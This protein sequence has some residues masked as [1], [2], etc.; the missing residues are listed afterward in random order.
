M[1]YWPWLPRTGALWLVWI[2]WISCA[3]ERLWNSSGN[4]KPLGSTPTTVLGWPSSSMCRP[5]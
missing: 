5:D 1:A 4:R 2:G 3:V